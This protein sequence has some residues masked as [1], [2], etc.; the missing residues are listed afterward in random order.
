MRKLKIPQ[1]LYDAL[2]IQAMDHFTI[3]ELR[4]ACFVHANSNV[5]ASRIKAYKTTYRQIERLVSKGLLAKTKP[6][7]GAV[8]YEKT[9]AFHDTEFAIRKAPTAAPRNLCEV[10]V[11][12]GN[13][14]ASQAMGERLRALAR[15][16]QVDLL[17]C[18]GES[19]E[20]IRLYS[21]FPELKAQLEPQYNAARERSSK[22][23]GKIKALDTVLA[24]LPHLA[25][26]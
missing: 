9:E 19:E 12:G 2:V 10:T 25:N 4:D 3:L 17:T 22:L 13:D 5:R 26:Q 15:S 11:H 7:L 23:L 1:R 20:Y 16:Y 8:R 21:D 6:E 14:G 18:I 24:Q